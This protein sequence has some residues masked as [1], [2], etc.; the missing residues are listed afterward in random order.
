MATEK[1]DT[2]KREEE[3]LKFWNENTI[4]EKTLKKDAPEGEYVFYDGPP[5]ATGTPHYGHLIQSAIK[6]VVP[7][8]WTMRGFHV[9]RQWGWDCHGLP[10]ENIV[11]KELETKSKKD[12]EKMGVKKFNDLCREKIFTYADV[13]DEFIPRFGRWADMENPYRTMD[14]DYMES[15][16][17]AFKALHEK[18]LIYEDYR[19]MH[20]CPR[21]ET[22][23]AQAEVAEGYADIKD[24]A[25]TVKF[26][27]KE[28][29]EFGNGKYKTK[30]S[31][32]ILAWTTTPWTLPGNV[33][34]AVGKDIAYTSLR[35]NGIPE[36]LIVASERVE[37]LFKDSDIEIVHDDMTGADLVGLEY[38]PPFDSYLN[39]ETLKNRENAWKV[40]AA[41]FVT[42]EDGTG[43]A[44]EAPAFG[45]EDM[46]LAQQV[47]LPLIQHVGMD[48]VIK[49]EVKELA[50]L[51]VKPIDDHQATD[52]EV[53][54]YLAG[55]EL[56][57]AKEK[58]EHSY[59]HCWRCD[60]PLI[61]YATSSWFVAVEKIKDD[62]L[63]YAEEIEWSPK[64]VKKGRWGEWLKGARDWS[65]SRQRFWANTIPVW[66]CD[67]CKH[68]QVFGS[69]KELEEASGA[70]VEDLHK[71][72]VD[73][74]TFA[75]D[76]GGTMRRVPD[77]LDTWF[78]SGSVPFASYHYP[79][80][81]KEKVSERIPA[82][83]IGEAQDQVSKWFYYQHVLG[84]ALFNSHVFKN[85]ITSGIVLAED[86]KKM[87]KRLQN[88]PDPQ[89]LIDTH[90]ADAVRLY[91]LASPVVRGENLN[92]SEDG[93]A[94]ISRKVMGRLMNV[95]SFYELY[96]DS[97]EHELSGESTHVLD[98]WIMSRMYQVR[99]EVTKA[100]DAYEL[101]RAARPLIEF[102][103]DLSTWY[104]R[105]SRER[106]KGD[107][108]A[109]KKAA[110]ETLRWVLR[111]YAKAAAP[112]TPFISE[113]VWART[114][115]ADEPESV[116]LSF[117]CK[118]KDVDT[119]LLEKM[120][121]VRG[122]VTAALEKRVH[123]GI[124]V[125]Q[126][127]ATL[128]IKDERIGDE[129]DIL[130]I[131]KDEVNVEDVAFRSDIE[132]EVELDT[133]ITSELKEKGD[134]RELT[135]A[136]QDARKKA[137]LAPGEQVS[138]VIL[139]PAETLTLVTKYS[140][141]LQKQTHVEVATGNE[142]DELSVEIQK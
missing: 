141:E 132:G 128:W 20:I 58:Y 93:V 129:Q 74:V 121:A 118:E 22:T 19:S 120:E 87:S 72:V 108:E 3:I 115:G 131:I 41:D 9:E 37:E 12:I 126:P 136:I 7:R 122:V 18:D 97:M 56:L 16:W 134:V 95:C 31:A 96:K 4:F 75:H 79:F 102:V 29:Q 116:H 2:A 15:E 33:A 13:W 51:S 81:N 76:C 28:G 38:E 6:D 103:D 85:V 111:K 21:C 139:G 80:E 142:A 127:L 104:V 23:L 11:E 64:H 137:G 130:D 71:D 27:L 101:D 8:Y 55:K 30:D 48:G 109:D 35:V 125:R 89:D 133:N 88:Y 65:I 117:W 63:K 105:R 135:R 91:M 66:R 50:G 47:G 94:E 34:L 17:W 68:D 61:N 123:A 40:Y 82:D 44:H 43:I 53:I 113:Y 107:D 57:F 90:G 73:E 10:I 119:A 112:F 5:F 100:M 46:E 62:L 25:V 106:F 54:K 98:R 114:K 77:V 67:T 39:D 24:L 32:Y 110:L 26:H 99:T 1:S 60:T 69:A 86:G 78:N 45:A 59:P 52:V 14:K 36:L 92:F 42:A 124:K 83:F 49:P 140:G 138:A 70:T 84:G